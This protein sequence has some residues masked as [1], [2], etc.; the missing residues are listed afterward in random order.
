MNLRF[1]SALLL[2]A[3]GLSGCGSQPSSWPNGEVGRADFVYGCSLGCDGTLYPLM[4]GT[5]EQVAVDGIA[6]PSGLVFSS[7]A[8]AVLTVAPVGAPSTICSCPGV[9]S[10]D[11]QTSCSLIYTLAIQAIAPGDA[12]L[13]AT[14]AAGAF[15]DALTLHVTAP[16]ALAFHCTTDPRFPAPTVTELT[17]TQSCLFHVDALD[18]QGSLLVATSGFS[19]TSA[20]PAVVRT[21]PV[22][23]FDL[24]TPPD[25]P[26]TASD[27][28]VDVEGPGS[29]E[30]G[31][32]AGSVSLAIP[33]TVP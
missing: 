23:W 11:P 27:G 18:A 15:F 19:I 4:V 24:S 7:E 12:R 6:L 2:A 9:G 10:C 22:L 28:Y 26:E 5:Q 14:T 16:A 32:R 33:V 17:L 1:A 3:A 25:P 8:P 30:V 20:D 31:V 21:R 29:T 13:V